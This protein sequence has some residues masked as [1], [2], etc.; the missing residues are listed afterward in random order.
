M[1]RDSVIYTARALLQ[2]GGELR[3]DNWVGITL[4]LHGIC[5]AGDMLLFKGGGWRR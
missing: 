1:L 3:W 4:H 5:E 2:G